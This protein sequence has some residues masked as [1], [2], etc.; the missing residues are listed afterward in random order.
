MCDND[1]HYQLVKLYCLF[2]GTVNHFK[3]EIMHDKKALALAQAPCG[4]P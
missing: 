1:I 3:I 4:V 2:F